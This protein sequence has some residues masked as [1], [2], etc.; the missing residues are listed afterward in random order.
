MDNNFNGTNGFESGQKTLTEKSKECTKLILKEKQPPC[1][2][3]W[4][5]KWY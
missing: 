4:I 1:K 5:A 3:D 2:V